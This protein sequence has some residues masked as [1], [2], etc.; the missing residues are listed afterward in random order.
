MLAVSEMTARC[1]RNTIYHRFHGFID[2]PTYL[3]TLLASEQ[4][5]VVAWWGSCCVGLAS[6]GRG[7][8]GQDLAVMV[9]DAWQRQGVGVA[10]LEALV[11]LARGQGFGLLHADVLFEDFFILGVLARYGRLQTELE[12]GD[13]SVSTHLHDGPTSIAET[14]S[15]SDMRRY[16]DDAICGRSR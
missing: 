6:L 7:M 15:V 11:D 16:A 4:M 14:C 12:Y 5:S 2:L 9:E 10:M 13:Y 8:R 1:S 3:G